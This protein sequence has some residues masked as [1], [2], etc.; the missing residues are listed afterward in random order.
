MF[1]WIVT[2]H[3]R[4]SFTRSTLLMMSLPKLSNTSIF[5]IGSPSAFNTGVDLDTR[6]FVDEKVS[7][8]SPFSWAGVW[9]RLRIRSMDASI[10]VNT[11]PSR[12]H[13][14]LAH[15]LGGPADSAETRSSSTA[16]KSQPC[17]RGVGEQVYQGYGIIADEP[18][19]SQ[20]AHQTWHRQARADI[21]LQVRICSLHTDEHCSKWRIT[22]QLRAANRTGNVT[23]LVEADASSLA[24]L[25][26]FSPCSRFFTSLSLSLSLSASASS[27]SSHQLPSTFLSPLHRCHSLPF[28]RSPNPLQ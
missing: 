20:S 7:C 25:G 4:K 16:P 2:P 18:Q 12:A 6:P 17:C 3:D 1:K 22:L 5:Q 15:Q 10:V 21:Q 9:L 27:F 19:S 13:L 8:A 28:Q 14:G 26:S 24:W 11:K 23:E